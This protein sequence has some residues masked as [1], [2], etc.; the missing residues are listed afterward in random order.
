[1]ETWTTDWGS[2]DRDTRERD[3]N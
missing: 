1:M 3:A 2:G